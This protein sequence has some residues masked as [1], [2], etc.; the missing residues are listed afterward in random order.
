MRIAVIGAGGVGGYF[1]ARLAAAGEDVT[2]VARGRHLTA[3][4]EKGLTVRSPLGEL[5]VPSEAVVPAISDLESPDLVMVA[6]KLWDTEDVAR[7]LAPLAEG[8]AAVVSFQNGVQKDTVLRRHLPAGSVLGGVG[9]ISAFIEEPGV[10][11]HN[12][13]LQ[14]LVFGEYDHTE[15]P[16]ARDFLDRAV[17]A[18]ID[19]EISADI[20]RAIWEKFVFLV[21]LSG[22]TSAVRQPIGVVRGDPGSRALLREVMH[23]VVAVGRAKGVALDPGFADDRL[24]FC[25]TLPAAMTSSMH[26]DLLHGNRLELGW[27]SGAVAGLGAELG[28]ATPR[29][30]AIAD[31]LSPYALGDPAATGGAGVSAAGAASR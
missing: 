30:R 2:L 3:I 4:R 27:L 11:V 22:T 21:G 31:I 25:D 9:Y 28:V 6:V 13:T 29:N 7:Q 18:G 1:G 16:R 20:E 10:V 5:R 15:S 19:A 23:E 8:G 26:N 24:A 12:G 14:R 17:A